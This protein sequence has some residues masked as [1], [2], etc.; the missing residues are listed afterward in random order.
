[1]EIGPDR[2]VRSLSF[3]FVA[4]GLVLICAGLGAMLFLAV[5]AAHQAADL[6]TKKLLIRMA[7]ISLVLLLLSLLL[8]VAAAF[9]HARYRLEAQQPTRPT[10]HVD[11]WAEAG[12]RFK[13]PDDEP[14]EDRQ[15]S[16][17]PDEPGR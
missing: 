2:T 8:L 10:P 7:W 11:A 6:P 1:M 3:L 4:V 5:S 14:R 12:R 16:D 17:G 15:D 9:R 13:L